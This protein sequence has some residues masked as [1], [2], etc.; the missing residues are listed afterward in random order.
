[1]FHQ[2]LLAVDIPVLLLLPREVV[3][4]CYF[5]NWGAT[6]THH[7]FVKFTGGTSAQTEVSFSES[8]AIPIKT[9]DTLP[10]YRQYNEIVDQL[11]LSSDN[12]LVLQVQLPVSALGPRDP[13][14]V[15]VHVK[16]SPL[17]KRKKNLLIKQI[18]LQM[19]E[20]LECFDGGLP[21][22]KENKFVSTT[23]EFDKPLTTEGMMHR[24]SFE[25]PHD[26]DALNFFKDFTLRNLGPRVVNSATALFNRNKNYP[27]IA[28][29]VPLTHVQGFTS[30]GKLFSLRY[31]ITVK[32][33]INHGKDMDLT[34]PI[35]VSPYDRD[36][37]VYLLLWIRNE[38]MLARDR[39]GKQTVSDISQLH[40]Q[41]EVQ[42]L[43]NHY[44]GAPELYF[45]K[46]E[47]WT[48]LGYDPRAFGSQESG[49]PLVTYI[50]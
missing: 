18:T 49:R 7:L 45:Y 40:S 47:D 23:V 12:Q 29:G 36:S 13:F 41:D 6:T 9:Y 42:R 1:M 26:N 33:K 2:E 46:K 44:C 22:R 8:F 19:R 27:K 25:F 31:E 34:I 50:D 48:S 4:S 39:F 24:F 30:S 20:V 38:C 17:H 15:D 10:L 3:A 14:T 21:P 5:D 37:C 32:V 28:E 43:L 11:C 16:A 35:M